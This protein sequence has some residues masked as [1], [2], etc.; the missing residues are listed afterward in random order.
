LNTKSDSTAEEAVPGGSPRGIHPSVPVGGIAAVV[1]RQFLP[2][3]AFLI[4]ALAT[5]AWANR[6]IQDDA[7]IS[8]RYADN[9]VR[10]IGLVWNSGERVEGYTN[11]LWTLL[12]GGGIFL[13]A[14]PV[15]F[16]QT[17]GLGCFIGSLIAACS[18]ARRLLGSRLLALLTILLL[19]TNYT[20]SAYATGGLE[21]QL[22][23]MLCLI[24][25]AASVGCLATGTCSTL[26]G[27][28]LSA[29]S[30]A[31][32]MTRPD[33]ILLCGTVLSALLIDGWQGERGRRPVVIAALVLPAGVLIGAW[34]GWKL[35][36]YGDILPNT[37]YIKASS[38]TSVERGFNFLWQF[39]SS[40]TLWPFLALVVFSG[41]LLIRRRERRPL[42]LLALM[43]VLWM[44]Y[45][46]KVGGDFMEFR[47]MVPI[48]PALFTLFVWAIF[49]VFKHPLLRAISIGVMLAGTIH[50]V[51]SF[52]YTAKNG[53]E[54]VRDLEGHLF[55]RDKN[56]AGIGR[57]LGRDIRDSSVIV[58]TTA[59]GAIPYYSR[60]HA[61]DM[62][63]I[64]D[65]WV[66]RNGTVI[67]TTPGHQRIA[68][69]SYL[70]RRSVNLVISHPLVTPLDAPVKQFPLI[71]WDADERSQASTQMSIVEIPIDEG[72]KVSALYLTP[73]PAVD[74]AIREHH[75]KLRI[76]KP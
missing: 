49:M 65:P 27:M 74:R 58:A 35:A 42:L 53:I 70:M 34:L 19:G 2:L 11:F 45:I 3:F 1:E 30:A 18:L 40:Y 26:R 37:F 7:F 57:A 13:G 15:T 17:V 59:A 71:P 32:V 36:Y 69:L 21:T 72:Y 44:L 60:L 67:S 75:W 68:P 61:V 55:D 52:S 29:L 22:Q 54:P 63:G 9:L 41:N 4:V 5:L 39:F 8:F 28:L 6:F 16:S 64:N 48:L 50:H 23:T 12:M 20:F 47:F 46:I 56:W 38:I 66:A 10:G 76:V 51:S 43:A 24:V 73:H 14:D 25:V 62:L 33:S 31:A